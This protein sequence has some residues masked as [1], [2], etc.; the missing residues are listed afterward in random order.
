MD[1]QQVS[2][3]SVIDEIVGTHHPRVRDAAARVRTSLRIAK[4]QR[5][6]ADAPF[7][8]ALDGF[9]AFWSELDAHL[10]AEAT[11]V[12]PVVRSLASGDKCPSDPR[13]RLL[14]EILRMEGEHDH[15]HAGL[16]QLRMLCVACPTLPPAPEW[17]ACAAHVRA[18]GDALEDLVM[19]ENGVLF[20]RAIALEYVGGC[21]TAGLR[22]G[23]SP[24][25]PPSTSAPAWVGR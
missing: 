14:H 11:H 19:M 8:R 17:Q 3:D 9:E 13:P 5:G 12:F 18:L 2:L 6:G 4:E 25:V 20:P 24:D 1:W 15:V 16:K 22:P 23:A 21:P 10:S 7:A